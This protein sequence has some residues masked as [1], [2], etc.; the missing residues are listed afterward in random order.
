MTRARTSLRSIAA[1]SHIF[2]SA[3]IRTARGKVWNSARSQLRSDRRRASTSASAQVRQA[4]SA[5]A[6]CRAR[7]PIACSSRGFASRKNRQHGPTH[8]D[9]Q[10]ARIVV[11]RVVDECE[12]ELAREAAGLGASQLEDRAQPRRVDPGHGREPVEPG[13][14][15]DVHEHGLGLIGRG[16]T[17]GD[18]GRAKLAGV[19]AQGL[20][21]GV[22]SPSWQ[23]RPALEREPGHE[24]GEPELPG[25]RVDLLGLVARLGT[26]AVVDVPNRELQALAPAQEHQQAQRGDRVRTSGARDE[27][28]VRELGLERGRSSTRFALAGPGQGLAHAR[29]HGPERGRDRRTSRRC[30]GIEHPRSLPRTATPANA[31]PSPPPIRSGS[32][33]TR[34]CP[35]EGTNA[36]FPTTL[37]RVTTPDISRGDRLALVFEEVALVVDEPLCLETRDDAPELIAALPVQSFVA[38]ARKLREEQR[39]DLLLPYASAD[40]ITGIFDLDAW[41]RDRLAT[42]RAR[43]WLDRIVDAYA[44]SEVERGRLVRLIHETDPEMWI[45][46]NTAATA[47]AEL[48]PND[49]EL[50]EQ[51]LE[52]MSSLVTW[53]TPDG[54]YVVGV[55]DNELG[56]MALRILSAVYDDNLQEGRKLVSAIKWSVHNEVEDELL[57]WRRG[58]LADLG[59]PEWEEAMRL[60]APL[61]RDVV[62]G[63]A[64]EDPE[65]HAH[66]PERFTALPPAQLGASHDVLRRVMQRLDD[67]EYDLRLREFLLLANEL[68]AA[69]RF[70]PGD[71]ALKERAVAQAQAT[72]NLACELLLA[73]ESFEDPDAYIASR[74]A[75]VGL[76]K[77][78]RF[79]YGPLAKL[80]KA[81]LALHRGGQVSLAKIGSL[82][83]RP[84]GPALASLS[85]W[86]PELPVDGKLGSRPLRSLADVARA[87]ALVGEAGALAQLCFDLDGFAVDPVWLE[88][89]DESDR[90]HLGDLVRTALVCIELGVP[91]RPLNPDDSRLGPR[92]PDR[93]AQPGQPAAARADPRPRRRGRGRRPGRGPGGRALAPAVGRARRA[94]GQ[95]RGQARP[96][97]GRRAADHPARRRVVEALSGSPIRSDQMPRVSLRMPSSSS[98]S[99]KSTSRSRNSDSAMFMLS[100]TCRR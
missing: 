60:F 27:Q 16:V 90:L 40:Q 25:Q 83:D 74:I 34:G 89:L 84:W 98:T 79:G 22:S 72:L 38:V 26:Q 92:Q 76:R 44:Q 9:P 20:A 95:R 97:Q 35:V 75:S 57:R 78:F 56:R 33:A 62:I 71:E 2:R 53:E 87:T 70:E 82:L 3:R 50:R 18:P 54:H 58:R 88:R 49:E 68:M 80:R 31:R 36:R 81:A 29:P 64:S 43:E 39:L 17:E 7:L 59:F 14:S 15:R 37:P 4:A 100:A 77:L 67:A 51:V 63:R 66:V 85:R 93:R 65:P 47:I 61:A 48:D 11:A 32:R 30:L 55:P 99:W 73:G 52:D 24:A 13:P 94:R 21:A 41:S 96:D 42:A 1:F 45:L 91:M 46:A 5:S 12:P 6:A 86:Y 69:Q 19:A 23:P 10:R 28:A 8:A